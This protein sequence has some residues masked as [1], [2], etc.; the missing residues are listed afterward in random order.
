[1]NTRYIYRFSHIVLFNYI[2]SKIWKNLILQA[3]W[4]TKAKI[5]RRA[6]NSGYDLLWPLR[7]ITDLQTT[8]RFNY[9][10]MKIYV[11]IMESQNKLKDIGK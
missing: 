8:F 9:H 10:A 6:Q 11:T 1:M 2:C 5:F 4:E 3:Q 7:V